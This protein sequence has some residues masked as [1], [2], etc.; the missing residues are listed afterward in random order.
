MTDTLVMMGE[1]GAM[2]I[3]VPRPT[4][5]FPQKV[6]GVDQSARLNGATSEKTDDSGG[7]DTLI[8][9]PGEEAV[10]WW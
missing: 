2:G 7:E 6:L 3:Y 9:G 4:S 10:L 1:G 8:D 5:A